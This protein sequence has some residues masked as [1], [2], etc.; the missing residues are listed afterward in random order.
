MDRMVFKQRE[1]KKKQQ[2]QNITY[3]HKMTKLPKR[4]QQALH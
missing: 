3:S 4:V 1:M 2:Q